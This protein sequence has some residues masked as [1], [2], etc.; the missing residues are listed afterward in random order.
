MD[1]IR[2]QQQVE[3]PYSGV[4]YGDIIY[5]CTIVGALLVIVGSVITFVTEANYIAPGY[6]LSNIWAGTPVNEIWDGAVGGPPDGHW[7]LT[8]L[9]TGNGLTMA[10]IALGVFSVIPGLL[11]GGVVLITE[12]RAVYGVLAVMAA[13]ITVFA[14][15]A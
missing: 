9:M 8:H 12:K 4:I 7:Y 1:R 6:L 3:I 2:E 13:A 11:V 10:G 5:W 15:V 14:M